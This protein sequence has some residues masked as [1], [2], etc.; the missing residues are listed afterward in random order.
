MR[1]D[2]LF[3]VPFLVR[4]VEAAVREAIHA[5]VHAYLESEGGRQHVAPAQEESFSTSCFQPARS[6]PEDADLGELAAVVIAA[7]K[8]FIER[9]LRLPP[10]PLEIERA[11]INVFPPGAQEVQHTH[12]GNLRL[13]VLIH[14]STTNLQR[15]N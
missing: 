6:I 5:K 15:R 3:P 2:L 14:R 12:D 11:W 7:A 10:R 4:D 13:R 1:V 9:D 8:E